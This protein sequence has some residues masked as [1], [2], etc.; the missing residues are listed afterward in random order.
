MKTEIRKIVISVL[1]LFQG[2]F[3]NKYNIGNI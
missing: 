1:K 3:W 2:Y